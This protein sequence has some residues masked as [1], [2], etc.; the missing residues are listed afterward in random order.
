MTRRSFPRVLDGAG[1]TILNIA[2]GLSVLGGALF[3]C[4]KGSGSSP[5]KITAT[6]VTFYAQP[7]SVRLEGTLTHPQATGQYPAVAL[8]AGMRQNRDARTS[9]GHETFS[10]LADHLTREGFVVLRYDKRGVGTSEGSYEATTLQQRAKDAAAALRFL[11]SRSIT[12]PGNTGLLGLSEGAITAPITAVR[13][14][15]AAFLVLLAAPSVP[16]DKLSVAQRVRVDS[17][18]GASPAVLD[19]IRRVHRQQLNVIQQNSDSMTIARR[20]RSVLDQQGVPQSQIFS[21][22]EYATQPAF[23]SL[24]RH[25]PQAVLQHLDVPVLALYGGNDLHVSPQ[26]NVEPMR[27]ALSAAPT[28]DA[29]VKVLKGLNHV[30]QP[31]ETGTKREIAQ[32]DTTI[33][34]KTLETVTTWIEQ[35]R[36]RE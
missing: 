13:H 20:L 23:R 28:G 22:V 9:G 1:A 29:T 18:R 17:A 7:D 14:E 19:S 31:A 3:D 4:W 24:I 34:Q 35:R 11:K 8:L 21:R 15:E 36:V 32:T 25:D 30:F 6:D 33:A 26:Q 16:F 2:I 12:Q 27:S 10:V 5:H